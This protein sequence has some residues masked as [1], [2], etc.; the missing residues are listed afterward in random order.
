MK[1]NWHEKHSGTV[2]VEAENP[3]LAEEKVENNTQEYLD[4]ILYSRGKLYYDKIH[5]GKVKTIVSPTK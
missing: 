1:I 4:E 3:K 5:I 2:F